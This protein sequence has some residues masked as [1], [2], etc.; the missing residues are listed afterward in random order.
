MSTLDKG[1]ADYTKVKSK[2]PVC[3]TENT[4]AYITEFGIG[5]VED[6]YT[7]D[8]CIYFNIMAYCR[9]IEGISQKFAKKYENEIKELDIE[10]MSDEDYSHIISMIL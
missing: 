1:Y 8:N 7:C 9:P 6:Y 2:C 4:R 10:V 5:M 3:G